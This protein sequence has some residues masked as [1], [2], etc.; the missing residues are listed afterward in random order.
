MQ[1]AELSERLRAQ[2]ALKPRD[3]GLHHL[4]AITYFGQGLLRRS[5]WEFKESLSLVPGEAIV[6]FNTGVLYYHGHFERKSEEHWLR[7]VELDP[8]MA[9]AHFN[10]CYLY[11]RWKQYPEALAYADRAE[12]IGAN[13]P[14]EL[15]RELKRLVGDSLNHDGNRR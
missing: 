9:D 11:Y 10:L 13:L 4:L 6:Q 7:T 2:I 12:R 8:S 1:L 15:L 14:P 3:A 5:E